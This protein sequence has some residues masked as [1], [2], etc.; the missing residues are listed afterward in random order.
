MEGCHIPNSIVLT[1]GHAPFSVPRRSWRG[2]IR[3]YWRRPSNSNAPL[4]I[5]RWHC[6]LAAAGLRDQRN[7]KVIPDTASSRL[8][9]P[10]KTGVRA[11]VSRVSAGKK[12]TIPALHRAMA[13]S[14]PEMTT[15]GVETTGIHRLR[16][17]RKP[18]RSPEYLP[19]NED[20]ALTSSSAARGT[21]RGWG[22][23]RGG[24]RSW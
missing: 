17:D 20:H 8:S 4:C 6:T 24:S 5:E 16:Q 14:R 19:Q 22:W 2:A 9:T 21:S 7:M 12:P 13:R 3:G 15:M 10:V 23:G 18:S 1:G 11:G